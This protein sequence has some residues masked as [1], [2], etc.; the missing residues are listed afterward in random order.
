VKTKTGEVGIAKAEEEGVEARRG[1]EE[2]KG[3]EKAKERK[4]NGSIKDSRRVGDLERGVGDS[5]IRGRSK[6]ASFRKI[7]Q[8]DSCVW[9]KGK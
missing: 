7:S 3:K 9:Q 4:K 5:K 6:K 1:R 8:V 2:E